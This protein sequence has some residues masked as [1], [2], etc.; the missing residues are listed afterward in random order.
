MVITNEEEVLTSFLGLDSLEQF[1][2]KFP[3]ILELR[4][5]NYELMIN[6]QRL[7]IKY[8]INN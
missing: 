4:I 1:L 2:V 8:V 3:W 5:I 6:Y 7:T